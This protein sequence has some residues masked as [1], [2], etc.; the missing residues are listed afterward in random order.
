MIRMKCV[1]NTI[2]GENTG[3]YCRTGMSSSFP[4]PPG[5][6]NGGILMR[7]HCNNATFYVD[8]SDGGTNNYYRL[9]DHQQYAPFKN[10]SSSTKVY[11]WLG[12]T[13]GSG[14]LKSVD[15]GATTSPSPKP[16]T[17]TTVKDETTFKY[18]DG[19]DA[20]IT[21]MLGKNSALEAIKT[22]TR[23]IGS[24][25]QFLP[26]T[27]YRLPNTEPK[28]G[29]KYA[30][31]IIAEAPIVYFVPGIPSYLPDFDKKNKEVIENYIEARYN[32]NELSS[33]VKKKI[34]NEEGRYFD[35]IANYADY[36]RYVNMLCRISA[37]YMGIGDLTVPGTT[38]KYKKYDWSRYTNFNQS[39]QKTT[40]SKSILQGM[41]DSI[42]D[43][44]EKIQ[45]EIFGD[46]KYLKVYVDPNFSF[47]ESA[48]NDTTNSQVA[49]LFDTVEGLAKD[50]QFFSSGDGS[51]ILESVGGTISD[52]TSKIRASF[53]SSGS[54]NISRLIGLTEET[55][56]G[57][58]VIFPEIW[59]DASYNKSYQ[60]TM[61]FISPYG[62]IE[63]IYLNVIM[64]MMHI[65]ALGLP[66][67]T[68]A[69]SFTSPFLVKVF[70]KGWFSCEMGIVDS[71]SIEKGGS[72]D[73]WNVH[74]LPNEVKVTISVK[75]L[76]SNLMITKS[77]KP[78]LFFNN[79]GLIDFLA[80]T[81]G[82]DITSPNLS[83]K[84]ETLISSYLNTL[85]DIPSNYYNSIIQ[86][87]RQLIEPMFKIG[88][89]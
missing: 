82:V 27:D 50:I 25:F 48:G 66:R 9:I 74:G 8:K 2:N 19:L 78:Q 10:V 75:D 47:S 55:I 58:N 34:F 32:D 85:F 41:W 60:F 69:N 20:Q 24:P 83:M 61:N 11:M 56:Q 87:I 52:V 15:W 65:I 7:K 26:E 18:S 72:G 51:S 59:G 4:V 80:V 40:G 86:D 45:D 3:A 17:N 28:L 42:T 21:A 23:I 62:D 38:T 76:Y 71:I 49:N 73:A 89:I 22:G 67:Q 35:F 63:S 14:F 43:T 6:T 16:S 64:P 54:S 57:S 33:A 84:L 44:A 29:R 37:I 39:E 88:N 79:Q 13:K 77:S 81:C 70:S 36:M 68:S 5:S 1:F 46:Y 12:S 31:N 53:D 30:E